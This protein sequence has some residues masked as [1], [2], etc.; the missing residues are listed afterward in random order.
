MIEPRMTTA[1]GSHT[2]VFPYLLLAVTAIVFAPGIFGDFV[3][4]D[5]PLIEHAPASLREVVSV[6]FW[7]LDPSGMMERAGGRYYRPVVSG[8]YAIQRAMFGFNPLGYHLVNL[9]LHLACVGLAFRWLARRLGGDEPAQIAAALGIVVFALH[10]SRPESVSW[11]SGSTDLWMAFW[12]LVGLEFWDK[13]LGSKWRW[14]ASA[15]FGLAALSKEAAYLVPALLACDALALRPAEQR[16]RWLASTAAVTLVLGFLAVAR[17]TWI[18]LPASLPAHND[19]S[20]ALLRVFTSSGYYVTRTIWP[21]PPSVRV[22]LANPD[23]SFAYPIL[24]IVVGVALWSSAAL[25]PVVAWRFKPLRPWLADLAWWLI[26]LLLVVQIIPLG[27]S[28]LAADRFLYLPLLGVSAFLG[29]A[30]IPVVAHQGS[31]RSICLAAV[32]SVSLFMGASSTHHTGNFLDD[33]SLWRYELTLSPDHP[34]LL[35]RLQKAYL[36]IG[37]LDEASAVAS[38]AIEMAVDDHEQLQAALAW[39]AIQAVRVDDHHRSELEHLRAFFDAIALGESDSFPLLIDDRVADVPIS[40]LLREWAIR[41]EVWAL[42]RAIL[43]SRT[44][45]LSEAE[46]MFRS[47]LEVR[48]TASAWANLLVTVALQDRWKEATSL[49]SNISPLLARAPLVAQ[50]R[51]L[52]L[53][54]AQRPM[55][56]GPPSAIAAERAYRYLQLDSS[57]HA[58]RV[59]GPALSEEPGDTVLVSL[60]VAAS[61]MRGDVDQAGRLLTQARSHAPEHES[62]WATLGRQIPSRAPGAKTSQEL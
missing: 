43:Y 29:R 46:A 5:H 38:R 12:L 22:G 17:L 44:Q 54:L 47:I 55:P 62:T 57:F 19:L 58:S 60:A 48:P 41:Q 4:D 23:G 34:S 50:K 33:A 18:N 45:R 31:R 3:W 52:V 13:P 9:F 61:L 28:V 59:L 24:Q 35:H 14:L 56:E 27:Y 25:A 53:V 26:P 21:W 11:I 32:G 2:K 10:P 30:L 42:H 36:R 16:K 20:T 6:N 8:A 40:G 1:P 15:A 51:D 39:A 37:A 7:E 49:A